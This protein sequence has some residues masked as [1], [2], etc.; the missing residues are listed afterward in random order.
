MTNDNPE[1]RTAI[2]P[3]FLMGGLFVI[4]HLLSMLITK[5]FEAADMEVF[6]DPND[7]GNLIVFFVIMLTG[8]LNSKHTFNN[9]RVNFNFLSIGW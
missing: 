6:N 1:K 2:F 5:P 4:I 7:L 3:M 9:S 8:F